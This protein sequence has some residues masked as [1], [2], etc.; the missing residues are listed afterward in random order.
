MRRMGR[1]VG[2]APPFGG[3][4]GGRVPRC[5]D[6]APNAAAP[7]PCSAGIAAKLQR[8]DGRRGQPPQRLWTR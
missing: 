4:G 5:L 7:A 6:V 8:R 1:T 2:Q 3:E